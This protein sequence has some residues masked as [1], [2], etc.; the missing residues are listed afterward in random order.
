[1]LDS[2]LNWATIGN[3]PGSAF[4]PFA[5]AMALKNGW[6]LK[7]T[8]QGNS[9]YTFPDGSTVKNE[10]EGTGENLGAKINLLY[11][12]QKSVNTAYIDLTMST[13]EGPKKIVDTAVDMGVPSDAPGLEPNAGVSLGS[14]TVSPI[15]MANAYA[16]IA[17]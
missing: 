14:A 7:D 4:K 1:Y 5:L 3:A 13:P 8:F 12:T 17:N 2:E 16:T 10:G 11:A 15:D 6:S 9:P